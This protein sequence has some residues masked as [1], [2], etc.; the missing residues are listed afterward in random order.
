ML[1]LG[2]RVLTSLSGF[3]LPPLGMTPARGADIISIVLPTL[4]VGALYVFR[5]SSVWP[6]RGAAR[7]RPVCR[8]HKTTKPEKIPMRLMTTW[9][10]RST[11]VEIPN[12]I[13]LLSK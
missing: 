10:C 13:R 9:N 1:F 2:M 4:A 11:D 5:M 6:V 3:A 7:G 12:V 8:P